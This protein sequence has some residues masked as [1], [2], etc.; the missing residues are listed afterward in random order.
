MPEYCLKLGYDNFLLHPF[1]FTTQNSLIYWPRREASHKGLSERHKA[2]QKQRNS[3]LLNEGINTETDRV[4]CKQCT[5]EHNVL[6][7]VHVQNSVLCC[8]TPCSLAQTC[9]RAPTATWCHSPHVRYNWAPPSEKV[10][11]TVVPV[12]AVRTEVCLL[13]FLTSAL[14]G[15]EWSIL[16]P[17]KNPLYSPGPT[18]GMDDSEDNNSLLPD[19]PAHSLVANFLYFW[20]KRETMN[21][22]SGLLILRQACDLW[23]TRAIVLAVVQQRHLLASTHTIVMTGFYHQPPLQPSKRPYNVTNHHEF[24]KISLK[25]NRCPINQQQCRWHTSSYLTVLDVHLSLIQS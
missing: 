1:Q 22:T 21:K 7:V 12:R 16:P 25:P 19:G 14:D 3:Q 10:K 9:R 13:S 8:M 24:Q 6:T 15:R 2:T 4:T 5:V 20:R 23:Q 11:G 17:G 18:A